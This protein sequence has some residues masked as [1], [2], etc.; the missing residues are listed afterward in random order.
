MVVIISVG[1]VCAAGVVQ[2]DFEAMTG[3]SRVIHR[4]E[5]VDAAVGH[6]GPRAAGRH[7]QDADRQAIGQQTWEFGPAPKVVCLIGF[8]GIFHF[9]LLVDSIVGLWNRLCH[10]RPKAQAKGASQKTNR[11]V[12]LREAAAPPGKPDQ[13]RRTIERR[14]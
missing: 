2:L 11:P 13:I 5:V 4:V 9:V 8:A 7:R 10:G 14:L 6:T 1:D 12:S 3:H